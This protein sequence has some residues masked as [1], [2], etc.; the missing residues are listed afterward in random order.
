MTLITKS[1][2]KR[3][4]PPCYRDFTKLDGYIS[5]EYLLEALYKVL[6]SLLHRDFVLSL[7]RKIGNP[8][9][10]KS[11]GVN[12]IKGLRWC[13]NVKGDAVHGNKPARL[14]PDGA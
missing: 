4:F 6:L 11:A 12:H 5:L 9:I 2:Q 1:G 3:L 14:D 7:N 8:S 10:R 13:A